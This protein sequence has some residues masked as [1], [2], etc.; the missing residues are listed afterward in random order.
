MAT[1]QYYS[2][3]TYSWNMWN[4]ASRR[5]VKFVYRC[6]NS[7]SS[8]VKFVARF[9]ILSGRMDSVV[10][11]NVFNCSL[12]YNT[13]VD[14]ILEMEFA[15]QYINRFAVASQVDLD[16]SALLLE[17]LQCRDGSLTLSNDDFNTT[18][19]TAMIDFLCTGWQWLASVRSSCCFIVFLLSRTVFYFF[20]MHFISKCYAFHT[21]R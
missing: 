15:P 3:S 6:L 19:I 16:I 14:R 20:P 1:A 2:L 4:I 21:N 7:Q 18:D 5:H 10:S 17:L 11:R 9:G 12:R 8:L 13:N